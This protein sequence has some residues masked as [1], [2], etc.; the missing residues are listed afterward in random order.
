MVH[1]AAKVIQDLYYIVLR[2]SLRFS[3]EKVDRVDENTIF[4]HNTANDFGKNS[5]LQDVRPGTLSGSEELAAL[6]MSGCTNCVVTMGPSIQIML[7]DIMPLI[8]EAQTI[9]LNRRLWVITVR[10]DGSL[11]FESDHVNDVDQHEIFFVMMN[12]PGVEMQ[13]QERYAIDLTHAQYG[14]HDETLMPWKTYVETRV[15]SNKGHLPLGRTRDKMEKFMVERF[16]Q[17]GLNLFMVT[18]QFEKAMTAA[19][20]DFPGWTKVW[21]EQ[22]ETSYQRQVEQILQHV[23][24]R[25]DQFIAA[26]ANDPIFKLWSSQAEKK[27]ME[28]G[29]KR[30]RKEKLDLWGPD[31]RGHAFVSAMKLMKARQAKERATWDTPEEEKNRVQTEPI[32]SV[33]GT[34]YKGKMPDIKGLVL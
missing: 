13:D 17:E 8:F 22:D 31:F 9:P 21:K 25:L 4:V 23:T 27:R 1:R 5:I 29:A 3:I 20:R 12:S 19:V 33:E 15:R 18:G 16:G 30:E 7:Q 24:T 2:K 26:K 28:A 32:H 6:T 10:P 11:N 34:A 14:H